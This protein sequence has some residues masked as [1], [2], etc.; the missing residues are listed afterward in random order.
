MKSK[1]EI[2]VTLRRVVRIH[3]VVIQMEFH[4]A[5]VYQILMAHHRIADM[6]VQSTKSAPAIKL[7]FNTNAETLVQGLVV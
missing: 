2:H 5:L 3:N 1:Y 7:A 6:S 4:H